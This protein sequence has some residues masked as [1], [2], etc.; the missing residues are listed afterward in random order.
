MNYCRVIISREENMYR[1]LDNRV[2]LFRILSV[3]SLEEGF[4]QRERHWVRGDPPLIE[5][6]TG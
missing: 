1:R 4:R 3:S 2:E 6:R 5:G